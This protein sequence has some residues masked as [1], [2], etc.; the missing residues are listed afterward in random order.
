VPAGEAQGERSRFSAAE[1]A[2]AFAVDVASVRPRQV[3]RAIMSSPLMTLAAPRTRETGAML[4]SYRER[5]RAVLRPRAG[6]EP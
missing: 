5:Y 4:A 6:S 3:K 1:I 2:A